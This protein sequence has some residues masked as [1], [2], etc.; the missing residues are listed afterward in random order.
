MDVRELVASRS[1]WL[2]LLAVCV[3]VGQTFL[4]AV[5]LYT[6]ASGGGGGPAALAQGLSPLEGILVPTFGAYDLAATLLFPFVVIRLLAHE[7]ETGA[8][9]LT[10]QAPAPFGV[11]MSV[12]AAAL[13]LAWCVALVPGLSTLAVWTTMG[14][15]LQFAETATLLVGYVLRGVMTIGICAAAAAVSASAAS[16]AIVALAITIGTWALDYAAAARGGVLARLA[17]YT[18]W[19]ALRTFERA[20]LRLAT[21]LITITVGVAGIVLAAIAIPPSRPVRERIVRAALALAVLGAL[22]TAWSTF[23]ASRDYSENRRNSFPVEDEAV[24]GSITEPLVVEV[25]LAAEDPRLTDLQHGVLAKLARSMREV[26]VTY[27]ARGRSGLFERADDHY[28]EVWYTL[29]GKREMSRSTIEEVVL[30]TVYGLA[31]RAVPARREAPY[32]GYP[33][34]ADTRWVPWMFFAGWPLLISFAW[35]GTRRRGIPRVR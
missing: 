21:V 2:L 13:L 7:R 19:A 33:L 3:L 34:V 12:R 28:G 31:G 26:R 27:V 32:A 16:G 14:G 15:H 17:S 11:A 22:S 4:N 1:Y 9:W 18:P 30:E 35:L 24:L 10:L 8:L 25:H 20:E 6:E 5:S 29:G 23:G